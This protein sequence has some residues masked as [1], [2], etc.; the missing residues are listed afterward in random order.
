LVSHGLFFNRNK[1]LPL[2]PSEKARPAQT[3]K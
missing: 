1:N 3:A 2:R